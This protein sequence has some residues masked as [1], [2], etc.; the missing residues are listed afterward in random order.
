MLEELPLSKCE[1]GCVSEAEDTGECV[2][3][4]NSIWVDVREDA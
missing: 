2:C 1:E 4:G 3:E